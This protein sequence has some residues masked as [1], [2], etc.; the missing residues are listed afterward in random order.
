MKRKSLRAAAIALLAIMPCV[1]FGR[2]MQIRTYQELFDAADLVVIGVPEATADTT[3]K[4]GQPDWIVPVVGVTTEFQVSGVMKGDRT[5]KKVVL[6]HYRYENAIPAR[7]ANFVKFEQA[8]EFPTSKHYLLFL[9]K[10][11]DGRYAPVFGQMDP[12]GV[13]VVKLDGI[14]Q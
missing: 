5:L 14:N 6:H 4:I 11:A 2:L 12:A 3:E 13:A 10:E 8:G 9:K 1:C 7:G